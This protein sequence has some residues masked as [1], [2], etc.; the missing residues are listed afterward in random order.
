MNLP[1]ST[2]HHKALRCRVGAKARPLKPGVSRLKPTATLAA[3][4]GRQERPPADHTFR[5]GRRSGAIDSRSGA[6]SAGEP[7]VLMPALFKAVPM[8][9]GTAG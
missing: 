3:A 4:R 1:E 2:P 5:G 7:E 9:L 6:G 8:L